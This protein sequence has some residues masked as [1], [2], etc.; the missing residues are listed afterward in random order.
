MRLAVVRLFVSLFGKGAAKPLVLAVLCGAALSLSGCKM[1]NKE[2]PPPC[3]RVSILGE[4]DNLFKFKDGGGQTDKD[5]EFR[6][7]VSGYTGA[8]QYDKDEK[9]MAVTLGVRFD[10]WKG[11]AMT[12]PKGHFSYFVAV[13]AF[14]GTQDGKKVLTVDFDAPGP[15]GARFSDQDVVISF[16]VRDVKD[17]PKYE[18]FIGMQLDAAQLDYNRKHPLR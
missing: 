15:Q 14:R 8:C 2:E 12:E 6:A 16:P 11:P 4:A 17:L 10:A 18:I 5:V 13:P 1:F 3:P 9:T 7:K